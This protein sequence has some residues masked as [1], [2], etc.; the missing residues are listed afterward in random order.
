MKVFHL[1]ILFVLLLPLD[2]YSQ[3][4]AL[5]FDDAPR[6]DGAYY[7]GIQR[8]DTLIQRLKDAGAAQVAFFCVSGNI[9][10]DGHF[11]LLKYIDAGH[12]IANHT[13]SHQFLRNIGYEGYIQDIKI[14]DS[15]LSRYNNFKKWF[16]FPF[17]QEGRDIP[18]RDN[19]R[20]ELKN[21]GYVNGYVTVDNYD[22]YIE[23]LFQKALKEK[24]KI[25]YD[26]LKDFYIEHIWNSIKFYDDIALKTIGRSA[27][28]V[29]LLHEN[30][31]AAL[32]IDDL[33]SYIRQQ[34]GEIITVDEAYT[35]PIFNIEP[36]TL[37]LYQ[38]RVAAIAKDMGYSE[39]LYQES[40]D[41]EWLDKY[42]DSYGIILDK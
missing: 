3:K 9:D 15:I 22:W 10:H 28:H 26:K 34:G 20:T 21:L 11:R 16:R 17:L 32:F 33:V 29:L 37:V 2:S 23:S 18:E 5:T 25:D 42:F 31:L 14:S 35:D 39:K 40:E 8:T 1:F 19:I 24:K 41:E 4:I 13:H 27:N 30:D 36:E 12:I 6:R 7:T 38:G